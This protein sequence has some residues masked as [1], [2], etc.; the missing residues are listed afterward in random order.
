MQTAHPQTGP[1]G[2]DSAVVQELRRLLAESQREREATERKASAHVN[3]LMAQLTQADATNRSLQAYLSFLKNSY[4]S[5]FQPELNGAGMLHESLNHTTN[6]VV[7]KNGT[8]QIAVESLNDLDLH[9]AFTMNGA[10]KG[11]QMLR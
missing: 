11:D 7:E 1:P 8:G 6:G 3:E 5:V 10:S 9:H 4:A 2:D